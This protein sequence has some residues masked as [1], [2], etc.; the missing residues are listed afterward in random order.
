[1]KRWMAGAL[2]IGAVVTLSGCGAQVAELPAKDEEPGARFDPKEKAMQG[3]PPEAQKAMEETRKR[4]M[5]GGRGG[6]GG[7][8]GP[9]GG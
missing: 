5:Q 1:M 6:P 8:G 4:M 7:P 2:L 3:M 9:G